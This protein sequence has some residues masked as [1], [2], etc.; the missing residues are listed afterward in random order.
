[1]NQR[2]TIKHET[3]FSGIQFI[4]ASQAALPSMFL[5]LKRAGGWGLVHT[6]IRL[7]GKDLQMLTLPRNAGTEGHNQ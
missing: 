2:A 7:L 4:T 3:I 1:M 6:A 5:A